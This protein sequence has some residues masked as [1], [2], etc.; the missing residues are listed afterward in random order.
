VMDL[1]AHPHNMNVVTHHGNVWNWCGNHAVRVCSLFTGQWY[2]KMTS[3]IPGFQLLHSEILDIRSGGNC[4]T[5][6]PYVHPH[7]MNVVK[8]LLYVWYDLDTIPG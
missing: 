4:M 7:H 3:I 2:V 1:P 8:Q 6:D 5:K